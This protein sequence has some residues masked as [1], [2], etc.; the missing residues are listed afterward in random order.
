MAIDPDPDFRLQSTTKNAWLDYIYT[1]PE[2]TRELLAETLEGVKVKSLKDLAKV[3]V[4][5]LGPVIRGDL[6]PDIAKAAVGVL[7]L[8]L[9]SL[10]ADA[11]KE[12]KGGTSVS[13]QYMQVLNQTRK[14]AQTAVKQIEANA[15]TLDGGDVADSI[16]ARARQGNG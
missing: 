1:V 3:S 11:A 10:I 5:M 14:E 4:A 15:I 12:G 13:V 2:E 6:A 8:T 7:E 9:K 16:A